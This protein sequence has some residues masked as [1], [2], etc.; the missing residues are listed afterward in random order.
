MARCRSQC[1]SRRNIAVHLNLLPLR[2][3]GPGTKEREREGGIYVW[4]T[5]IALLRNNG[6]RV[7]PFVTRGCGQKV[8][9][10]ESPDFHFFNAQ[11]KQN[12]F[13][14]TGNWI[15]FDARSNCLL[16][17][18]LPVYIYIYWPAIGHLLPPPLHP[19]FI[20]LSQR[21]HRLGSIT[22]SPF[23]LDIERLPL[24]LSPLMFS[25]SKLLYI[26]RWCPIHRLDGLW[27]LTETFP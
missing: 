16:L 13:S 24:S 23:R 20:N 8:S 9:T 14:A 26:Y 21:P 3:F 25:S 7:P 1:A 10:P 5:R 12:C 22:S 2:L 6:W 11:K 18:S 19:R 27:L 4:T 15:N 17:F